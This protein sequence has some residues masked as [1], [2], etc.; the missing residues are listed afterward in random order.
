MNLIDK[1]REQLMG[2]YF[3]N[4]SELRHIA[5]GAGFTFVPVEFV[6]SGEQSAEVVLRP[7]EVGEV[8]VRAE[9]PVAWQPYYITSVEPA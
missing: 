6:T 4:R 7:K 5:E 1:L 9:R 8:V 2:R 3:S